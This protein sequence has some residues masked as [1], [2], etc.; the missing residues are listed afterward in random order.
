MCSSEQKPAL[1]GGGLP[2]Q[3]TA[4]DKETSVLPITTEEKCSLFA[5][6]SLVAQQPQNLL[7]L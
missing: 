1:V 5:F 4:S 6:S 3:T 7:H 2:F